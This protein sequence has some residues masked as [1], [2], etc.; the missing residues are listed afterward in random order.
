MFAKPSYTARTALARSSFSRMATVKPLYTFIIV[1]FIWQRAYLNNIKPQF[2]RFLYSLQW[3]RDC[4]RR[5]EHPD[6]ILS[7]GLPSVSPAF[8]LS[9]CPA[10]SPL[11]YSQPVILASILEYSMKLGHDISGG[12]P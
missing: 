10:F 8:R 11:N 6:F 7:H 3:I 2:S 5:Q 4:H 12:T 9:G 1:E